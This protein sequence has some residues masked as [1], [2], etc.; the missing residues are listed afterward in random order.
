[1]LVPLAP[2]ATLILLGEALMLKSGVVAGLMVRATVVVWL[3]LPDVPVMV[4]VEVPAATVLLAESV[5][6]PL[7]LND[8]VTP[9]G[10]PE[11]LNATVLLNPF[12]GVTVI[13]LVPLAPGARVNEFG[14]AERLKSAVAA[15]VNTYEAVYMPFPLV[16]EPDE[17]PAPRPIT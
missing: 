7:V 11:A 2:G 14:E 3:R 1:M 9:A 5:I 16:A 4:T 8:A 12:F 15:G 6:T 10:R 13:V 17:P